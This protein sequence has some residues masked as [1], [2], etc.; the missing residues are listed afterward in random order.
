MWAEAHGEAYKYVSD[1]EEARRTDGCYLIME[2]DC[3]GQIL[4]TCPMPLVRASNEALLLLLS[5][6]ESITW[7]KGSVDESSSEPQCYDAE[8]FFE[9]MRAGEGVGGGMGGGLVTDR[10][11]LH[12]ELTEKGW[13]QEIDQVVSGTLPRIRNVEKRGQQAAT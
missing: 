6:L 11:W 10:L 3:G 5:D 2:A 7:G 8:M 1:F 12:P 4:L 9:I 13:T